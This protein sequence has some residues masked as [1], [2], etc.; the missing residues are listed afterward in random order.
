MSFGNGYRKYL[1]SPRPKPCRAITTR[2]RKCSSLEYKLDRASHSPDVR[3]CFSIAFPDSLRSLAIPCQSR[4]AMPESVPAAS[5]CGEWIAAA[6]IVSLSY[7]LFTVP[8]FLEKTVRG[9]LP[10]SPRDSGRCA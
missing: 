6:E 1:Y 7:R 10:G 8:L 5:G 9:P 3:T 2:L 4:N